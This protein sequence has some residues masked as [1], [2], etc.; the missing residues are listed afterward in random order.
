VESGDRVRVDNLYGERKAVAA[1]EL[2]AA[3]GAGIVHVYTD[4]ADDL[5]LMKLA[6]MITLVDPPQSTIAAADRAGLTYEIL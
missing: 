6:D 3:S 2:I 5:A 1:A 4:H